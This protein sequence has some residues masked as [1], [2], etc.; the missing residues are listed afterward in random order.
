[1][2]RRLANIKEIFIM[3]KITITY[4]TLMKW[5]NIK[6]RLPPSDIPFLAYDGHSIELVESSDNYNEY[7]KGWYRVR[8]QTCN[9]CSGFC[10]V[11]PTHWMHLPEV[12]F[13]RK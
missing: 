8:T 2:L 4:G 6:D 12:P 5:I 11:A 9:C 10:S 3:E 13:E 1:M 7:C